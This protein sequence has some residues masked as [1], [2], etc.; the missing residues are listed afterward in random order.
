MFVVDVEVIQQSFEFEFLE[1]DADAAH[2]AGLIS[3]D[4]VT[5][6]KDHIAAGCSHIPGEGVQFEVVLTAEIL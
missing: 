4:M 6:R 3:D 2:D 5:G 1:D